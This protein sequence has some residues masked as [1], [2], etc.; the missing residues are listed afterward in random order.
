MDMM[1]WV[2]AAAGDLRLIQ[3]VQCQQ[4]KDLRWAE[5]GVAKQQTL[6]QLWVDVIVY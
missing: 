5:H 3:R 4:K 2:G 6:A 1:G